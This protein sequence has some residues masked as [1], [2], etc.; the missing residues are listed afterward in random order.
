MIRNSIN[1]TL[2]IIVLATLL[3]GSFFVMPLQA[4]EIEQDISGY[5]EYFYNRYSTHFDEHGY[6]FKTPGYGIT[7]FS[8]PSTAREILSLAT[9]YKYRAIAGEDLAMQKIRNAIFTAEDELNSRNYNTQSFSDAWVQMTIMS[10]IDQIPYL[11]S[12]VE[13]NML[14]VHIAER[15]ESGII[16][17]DTS[18][19]AALSAVYWQH[20]LNSLHQKG[21]LD[22]VRKSQLDKLIYFKIKSVS[23]TDVDQYGWYKEGRNMRFNPHYHMITAFCFASYAELTGDIE[24]YLKG[25]QMTRN[26]RA[27]SF[28]NGMIEARIGARPVGLGAQFYLGTALLN[29]KYGFNDF[30]T[31][32]DYAKL[33]KFFSDPSFPN[34]LE[35]HSTLAGTDP[36]YHDDISFSN[37]SELALLTPSMSDFEFNFSGNLN[38]Y[39]KQISQGDITVK[40]E[41]NV[42]YFNSLKISQDSSSDFTHII[43][44][45]TNRNLATQVKGV[46]AIN[47]KNLYRQQRYNSEVEAELINQFYHDL[48]EYFEGGLVPISSNTFNSLAGSYIYGGYTAEE[49]ADTIKN[50]PRAVHPE[51]PASA[52]RGSVNYSWYLD[53]LNS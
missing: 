33:D 42:V 35:Y 5:I 11:L 26:L 27:I 10:L 13:A 21:Y 9:Y 50:G 6:I 48:Q 12:D 47:I 53:D 18:N 44:S 2:S 37:L 7:E 16:A 8:A 19:R 52:W 32:L 4:E 43:N 38:L 20:T 36:L 51:F 25:K 17:T 31:Y 49:I 39:H 29:K 14:L 3:F 23:D 22:A 46:S 34:R 45:K 15:A 40:N 24:L 28:K 1:K 30:A 41:G